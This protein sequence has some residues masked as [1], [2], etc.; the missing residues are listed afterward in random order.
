M[1]NIWLTLVC[2]FFLIGCSQH[3]ERPSI[4]IEINH[5]ALNQNTLTLSG[6][7]II[8]IDSLTLPFYDYFQLIEEEDNSYLI[9]MNRQS[10]SLDFIPLGGNQPIRH[11]A[12][13]DDGPGAIS[14]DLDIFHYFGEDSIVTIQ[15]RDNRLKVFNSDGELVNSY[16]KK[17]RDSKGM[18]M[19]TVAYSYLGQWP[20]FLDSVWIL[21]VY[22]D[23]DVKSKGYYDRN[24]FMV[25]DPVNN[26]VLGEFGQYPGIYK[27]DNYFDILR[28]PS[29]THNSDC[30]F[31]VTFPADPSIYE[32]QLDQDSVIWHQ[33][34][35]WNNFQNEG[36]KRDSDFQQFVNHYLTSA[37]F[38]QLTYDPFHHVYY[39][40]AKEKQELRKA[41]GE[42]KTAFEADWMVFILSEALDPIGF[43]SLDAVRFN[44]MFSFVTQE[45]LYIYDNQRANDDQM[46]FGVFELEDN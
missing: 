6:S 41:N 30:S 12:F 20:V 32:Y 23:L 26:E 27:G 40:F 35:T 31:L 24:K 45:G 7:K 38:Q 34:P 2:F 25:F 18:E 8:L 9:G 11:L 36:V 21:P 5:K 37:W 4:V 43:Y 28:E 14:P 3:I 33:Y 44:P 46:V 1:K 29:L 42:K 39:R 22:P 19:Y 17:I 15:D 13:D 16:P 10:V